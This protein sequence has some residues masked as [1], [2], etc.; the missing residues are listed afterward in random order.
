MN[1]FARFAQDESGAT[2]I[3][4]GLIAALIS[5][6]II[7]AVSLLGS[8]LN[9]TFGKINTCLTKTTGTC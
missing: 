8:N 9:T 4:Y 3:E 6:V 1:I 7:G 5:V 2:A